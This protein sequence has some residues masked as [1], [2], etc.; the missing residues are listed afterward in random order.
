MK[1]LLALQCHEFS[2][3]SQR[4]TFDTTQPSCHI[5]YNYVNM[6]KDLPNLQVKLVVYLRYKI[7]KEMKREKVADIRK[8]DTH[9]EEPAVS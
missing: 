5:E 9:L 4:L 2:H 7:K 1:T 3:L 6:L 8:M